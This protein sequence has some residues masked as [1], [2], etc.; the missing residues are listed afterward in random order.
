MHRS[1]HELGA[2]LG[3]VPCGQFSGEAEFDQAGHVVR[4]SLEREQFNGP[5]VELNIADIIRE[6]IRL[7]QR[8]GSQ[9]LEE[10][11]PAV[12]LHRTTY[13]V[14]LGLSRRLAEIFAE[15][16]REYLQSGEEDRPSYRSA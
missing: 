5:P 9:F 12:I 13:E 2:S 15:D 10:G 1:F 14:F 11:D 3:G 7:R 4:I 8:W 6:R 16:I